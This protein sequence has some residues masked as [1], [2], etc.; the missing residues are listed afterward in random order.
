MHCVSLNVPSAQ[1]LTKQLNELST[2]DRPY[3]I[4][5]R[6]EE[7]PNDM[8]SM[9]EVGA[10]LEDVTVPFLV[11]CHECSN[12]AD[13]SLNRLS[14]LQL[15]IAAGASYVDIEYEA[16]F[17]YKEDVKNMCK[18]YAR[19]QCILVISYHNYNTT[20]QTEELHDIIRQSFQ[21][22]GAHIVKIAT[23]CSSEHDAQRLMDLY[24]YFK[25]IIAIGMGPIGRIT[26]RQALQLGAPFSFVALSKDT[27]TAPGQ[28]TITET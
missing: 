14:M 4:E 5:I 2:Y 24:K 9:L 1:A 25:N 15:G 20:P 17:T 7:L 12:D 26:R 27:L 18:K 19:K 23:Q 16:P 13:S 11:R 3:M 8:K 21:Q 22:D 10:V 6:L 28:Y